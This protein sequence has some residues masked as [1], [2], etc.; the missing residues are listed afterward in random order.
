[1]KAFE[2]MERLVQASPLTDPAEIAVFEDQ[3]RTAL[4][5]RFRQEDNRKQALKGQPS[6]DDEDAG[7]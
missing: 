7:S 6:L 3:A 4:R 2:E 1:M 5:L